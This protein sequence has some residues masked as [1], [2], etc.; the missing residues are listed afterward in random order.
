MQLL[1]LCCIRPCATG[2]RPGF[3]ARAPRGCQHPRSCGDRAPPSE[4]SA[5]RKPRHHVLI[6]RARCPPQYHG[7]LQSRSHQRQMLTGCHATVPP[8]CEGVPSEIIPP[9]LGS[10]NLTYAPGVPRAC[11]GQLPRLQQGTGRRNT[12]DARLVENR[13]RSMSECKVEL[14]LAGEQIPA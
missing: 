12:G 1:N 5:T 8:D 9:T 7:C 10:H 6:Q 2:A 4:R 14:T 11:L 3:P 13:R